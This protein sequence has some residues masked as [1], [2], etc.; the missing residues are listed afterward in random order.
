MRGAKRN[1]ID[2]RSRVVRYRSLPDTARATRI[3]H[4]AEAGCVTVCKGCNLYQDAQERRV[5]S[6]CCSETRCC[7]MRRREYFFSCCMSSSYCCCIPANCAYYC[8]S[9]NCCPLVF[10]GNP[11]FNY[12]DNHCC[13]KNPTEI[14]DDTEMVAVDEKAAAA[15]IEAWRAGLNKQQKDRYDARTRSVKRARPVLSWRRDPAQL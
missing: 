2:R 13:V 8:C 3:E 15:T 5:L 6:G 14:I 10:F 11:E 9:Y 7:Y 1:R 12:F 4:N